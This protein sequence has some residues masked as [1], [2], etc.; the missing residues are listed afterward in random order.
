MCVGVVSCVGV[1]AT[2]VCF[3]VL[4]CVLGK[5]LCVLLRIVCLGCVGLLLCYD[6]C[7]RFVSVVC[8]G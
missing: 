5:W 2:S 4:G 8:I 7:G 1:C 6:R 3:V